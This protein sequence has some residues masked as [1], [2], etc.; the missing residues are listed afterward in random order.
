MELKDINIGMAVSINLKSGAVVSGWVVA[1]SNIE[2]KDK[3]TVIFRI[4]LMNDIT[5]DIRKEDIESI[6][7]LKE[8]DKDFTICCDFSDYGITTDDM[9]IRELVNYFLYTWKSYDEKEKQDI[10]NKLFPIIDVNI[11]H[12]L[13]SLV[14]ESAEQL[15]KYHNKCKNHLKYKYEI[16]MDNLDDD[17]TSWNNALLLEL[18]SEAVEYE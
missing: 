3:T 8:E 4:A 12:D 18:D 2:F 17:F 6:R 13:L 7:Y 1:K 15:E 11:F 10:C 9:T 5:V 14:T 16:L